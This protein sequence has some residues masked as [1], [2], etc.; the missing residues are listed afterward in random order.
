[1]FPQ[2]KKMREW[3]DLFRHPP[4][5]QKPGK[6]I[7]PESHVK[8]KEYE[9]GVVLFRWLGGVDGMTLF[10]GGDQWVYGQQRKGEEGEESGKDGKEG[11]ICGNQLYFQ[12]EGSELSRH[13]RPE[14]LSALQVEEAIRRNNIEEIELY[15]HLLQIPLLPPAVWMAL[16]QQ[17]PPFILQSVLQKLTAEKGPPL[18]LAYEPD[19]LALRE[20]YIEQVFRRIERQ[21]YEIVRSNPDETG[22]QLILKTREVMKMYRSYQ[23]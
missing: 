19:G 17:R 20:I 13:W 3:I 16:F 9:N 4:R 18:L 23:T 21:L 6:W 8:L 5:L 12:I 7:D 14:R 1:M 2:E 11:S 22:R 15:G 10:S